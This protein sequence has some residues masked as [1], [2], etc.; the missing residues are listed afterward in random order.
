MPVL[1]DT[2]P[3]LA[4][5]NTREPHHARAVAMMDAI[6]DGEHGK[7]LSIDH[8]LQEGLTFLRTRAKDERVSRRFSSLFWPEG[9]RPFEWIT[10]DTSTLR[11]ATELHFDHYDR[12]LSMTDCILIEHAKRLDA[13]VATLDSGFEGLCR[14][15]G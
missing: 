3:L 9:E 14:T 15:I 1:I 6:L 13:A 10:T 7:P 5:L 11:A 8:V 4:Y 12:R 2:G